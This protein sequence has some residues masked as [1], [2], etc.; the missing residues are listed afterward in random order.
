MLAM[1]LNETEPDVNL[2]EPTKNADV[3]SEDDVCLRTD[4]FQNFKQ[5]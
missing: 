5:K 4:E 3:E 1:E 2:E